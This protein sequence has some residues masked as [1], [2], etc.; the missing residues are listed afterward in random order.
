MSITPECATCQAGQR[1]LVQAFTPGDT[2]DRVPADQALCQ[3]GVA[4][5]RCRRVNISSRSGATRH[6]S[7]RHKSPWRQVRRQPS[8]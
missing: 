3:P 6:S 4:C 7:L 5:F 2:S 8:P 1:L